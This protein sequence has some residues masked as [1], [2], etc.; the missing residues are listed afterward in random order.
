M[1]YARISGIGSYLPSKV[2][3]NYDLEQSL[4]TS[5]EWIVT[6]TGIEQ[7]HVVS[8]GENVETMG[9]EAS[10]RALSKAQLQAS[11]LDMIIGATCTPEHFFPSLA[12]QIQAQLASAPCPAFD[13][14]AACT[15]F[16]YALDTARQFI[17]SGQAQHVLVVGSEAL[18]KALNWQDRS[19]CVLF[20][21]GAGAM[22]LS[23]SDQPGILASHLAADGEQQ[24]ILSLPTAYND[25][26]LAGE[27]QP[28]LQ[29]QGRE[30]FR[31]AVDKLSASITHI[32]N[33]AQLEPE[34]LDWLVPHQA[35]SRIL[36]SL[37][38]RLNMSMEQVISTVQKH[39]NTSSAS[40][41]LA[42]DEAVTSERIQPGDIVLL[43]AFG[44]GL[45][46]GGMV[47]Q[48]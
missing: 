7:R 20:G 26:V 21:D 40:I 9:V 41:P 31:H 25:Q 36:H 19:T 37:A 27:N 22:V 35:N 2:V 47:L 38:K 3:T 16:I 45:T 5:N 32:L 24:S 43:E 34:Q 17:Q 28:Y 4:D 8:Q 14:V 42:F 15:G 12:C 39:A 33:E 13:I 29:M 30:V 46:W 48:Y 1:T 11:D 18:S 6:R 44:G 23:A 10:R